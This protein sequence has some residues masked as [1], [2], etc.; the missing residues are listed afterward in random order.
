MRKIRDEAETLRR[1]R[2]CH[3]TELIET[4]FF[5]TY[6]VSAQSSRLETVKI[7]SSSPSEN[8][9]MSSAVRGRAYKVYEMMQDT[10]TKG[11][12]APEVKVLRTHVHEEIRMQ[13]QKN[14]IDPDKW[15]P[16]L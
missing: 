3:V 15:R 12:I 1:A 7:R 10:D 6:R 14:R 16:I 5:K 2:H 9:G 8:S 13:G 11:F 4:Y